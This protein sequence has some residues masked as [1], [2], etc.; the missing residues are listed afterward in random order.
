M[1]GRRGE[2]AGMRPAHPLQTYGGASGPHR[3]HAAGSNRL[4]PNA[5]PMDPWRRAGGTRSPAAD[6]MMWPSDAY[7]VSAKRAPAAALVAAAVQVL[8]GIFL[9][10]WCP[11]GDW[12][13]NVGRRDER[14]VGV[15]GCVA[16]SGSWGLKWGSKAQCEQN[17][18]CLVR[19]GLHL[20]VTKR[21]AHNYL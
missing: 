15:S 16:A 10:A 14:C 6:V 5:C 21:C 18:S 20:L 12:C 11:I 3:K 19:F 9:V 4:T 2:D 7:R 8:A 1:R 17:I 13:V